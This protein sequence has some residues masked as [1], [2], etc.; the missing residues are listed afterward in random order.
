MPTYRKPFDPLL[1]HTR[2]GDREVPVYELVNEDGVSVP[3]I[4]GYKDAQVEYDSANIGRTPKDLVRQAGYA[5]TDIAL[6]PGEDVD[7]TGIPDSPIALRK[8]LT[9]YRDL[10]S[11]FASESL[12][13]RRACN[14]DVLM[15]LDTLSRA[16]DKAQSGA[17]E[18]TPDV[19]Q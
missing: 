12:D 19:A 14:F 5:G 4:T 6:A 13:V 8:M 3:R 7:L 9:Q 2:A 1:M 18:V 11:Q 10:E 16:Y 17:K 15:Y